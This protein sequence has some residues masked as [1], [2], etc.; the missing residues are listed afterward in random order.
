M[1]IL[2]LEIIYSLCWN[3]AHGDNFG[4]TTTLVSMA[5]FLFWNQCIKSSPLSACHIY[6]PG[7]GVSIGS[8]KGFSTVRRQ[9]ITWTNAGVLLI[10]LIGRNFNEIW[11]EIL[12]FSFKKMRLKM[13][14][15]KMAAILSRQRW[16]N[17]D[18]N[19]QVCLQSGILWII[20]QF[21]GDY[22]QWLPGFHALRGH[23]NPHLRFLS[24]HSG[25]LRSPQDVGVCIIDGRDCYAL[26]DGRPSTPL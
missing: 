11:I 17:A 23:R 26:Y 24:S 20:S 14:S 5:V 12:S 18:T 9:A 21:N 7:N 10:G 19:F 4:I 22:W 15:A 13:L 16:V 6:A 3:S 8:D 2:Y 25:L 1:K